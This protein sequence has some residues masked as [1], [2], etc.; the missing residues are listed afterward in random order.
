MG[1]FG[2]QKTVGI[3]IRNQWICARSTHL[4][5]MCDF[6]MDSFVESFQCSLL[7][8][9]WSPGVPRQI[10][11]CFSFSSFV[12]VGVLFFSSLYC[13]RHSLEREL[14]YYPSKSGHSSAQWFE[15]KKI[16]TFFI[17]HFLKVH[18]SVF[19]KPMR[20]T[21]KSQFKKT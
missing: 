3:R 13:A 8:Q 17:C 16:V 6:K 18:L 15:E 21:R 11:W 2:S 5:H 7:L 19:L 14:C 20:C 1:D 9:C 4:A 10:Q 12:S